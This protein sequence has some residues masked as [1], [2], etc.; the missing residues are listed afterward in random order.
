MV[1]QLCA[2]GNAEPARSTHVSSSLTLLAEHGE[3]LQPWLWVAVIASLVFGFLSLRQGR[4]RTATSQSVSAPIAEVTGLSPA[5]QI[6][7]LFALI[8]GASQSTERAMAAH[9]AAA[10][11]LDSAE[12]QLLRLFDE[13][14]TLAAVRRQSTATAEIVRMAAPGAPRALAA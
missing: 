7:R 8:D 12:Y 6:E 2:P 5:A 9:A 4:V 11:H 1:A 10:K 14:P 3:A 13:F